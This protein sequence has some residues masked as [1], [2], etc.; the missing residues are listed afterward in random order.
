MSN[1]NNKIHVSYTYVKKMN[2]NMTVMLQPPYSRQGRDW[3][4]P[5]PAA[6]GWRRDP[7]WAGRPSGRHRATHSHTHRHPHWC[8]PDTPIHPVCTPSGMWEEIGEPVEN[9]RRWENVQTP[10]TV[11]STEN[12]FFFLIN[13]VTKER[14]TK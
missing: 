6:Q 3:P 12:Q 14:L 7:P 1:I 5:H 9:P 8:N 2:K 13:I 11:A 4:E 10:Q